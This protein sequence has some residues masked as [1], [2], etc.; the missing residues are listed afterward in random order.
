MRVLWRRR[1]SRGVREWWADLH[2]IEQRH[3]LDRARHDPQLELCGFLR[4]WRDVGGGRQQRI[5][6]RLV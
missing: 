3:E 1:E 2:L 5:A 4:R 6:L